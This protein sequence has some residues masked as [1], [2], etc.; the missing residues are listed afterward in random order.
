MESADARL[1]TVTDPAVDEVRRQLALR[2]ERRCAQCR[3]RRADGDRAPRRGREARGELPVQGVPCR[4][5]RVRWTPEERRACRRRVGRR[6]SQRMAQTCDL[7]SR[8]PSRFRTP[9][10]LVTQEEESLRRQHLELT[11]ACRTRSRRCSKTSPPTRSRCAR[12]R[13]ARAIFRHRRRRY[14]RGARRSTRSL[15]RYRPACA[16]RSVRL[17]STAARIMPGGHRRP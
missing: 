14:G 9:R 5:R 2:T 1:A 6:L 8:A 10:R 12:S 17:R 11:V 7:F 16:R 13:V 3:A 4:T 15:D